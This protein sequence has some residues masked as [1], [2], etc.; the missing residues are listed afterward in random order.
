MFYREDS[1]VLRRR[2]ECS[3]EKRELFYREPWRI[4]KKTS[5]HRPFESVNLKP[6]ATKKALQRV[7]LF[8]GH[9]AE[10]RNFIQYYFSNYSYWQ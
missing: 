2:L 3:L 1:N 6:I 5:K 10:Y 9:I 7:S 8:E 4:K